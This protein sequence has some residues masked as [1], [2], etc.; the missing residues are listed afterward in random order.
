MSSEILTQD[1]VDALLKGV[2]DVKPA[3]P[4]EEIVAGARP[5]NLA[6]QERIVRGRMPTLDVI[7]ERI[8]R[9]L[10]AGLFSLIR[11][12]PQ[13]SVGPVK[14][15]K[16]SEFIRELVVP[17]NINV[18]QVRP[19][20][21][22]G[23][24][25]FDPGLVFAIVDNMFGGDGR[26]HLRVEGRDFTQTEHRI[27]QRVLSVVCEAY[28]KSWAPVHP[29]E[30][31]QVRSEV[32][33]QFASIAT[34]GEVVV[35]CQFNV[36]IGPSGGHIQVCLPYAMLEPIREVLYNPLPGDNP[37]P[38]RRWLSMLTR[39]VQLAQVDLVAN[40]ARIP[41]T[42]GEV[43]AMK[44]GDVISL[45]LDEEIIAEVD[46][47]PLFSCRHGS[48][49]GRYAVKVEKVLAIPPG[50]NELGEHHEQ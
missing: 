35:A 8:A 7:N 2:S 26:Y 12:D 36:E 31:E 3:D 44:V 48:L 47:V 33:P 1:E 50:E 49:N 23:L 41:A 34:P 32:H 19:L 39:Q 43:V 42:L 40:L 46:G 37:E 9:L 24:F 4:A 14:T 30:F 38:D 15:Q 21:G 5:Y 6:K 10:K 28:R 25:V 27:I 22:H 45:D 13:I 29:L 17:S 20:R 18:M 16:F 11:R